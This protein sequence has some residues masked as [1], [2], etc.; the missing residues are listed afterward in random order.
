[1]SDE[2]SSYVPGPTALI[3]MELTFFCGVVVADGIGVKEGV[4]PVVGVAS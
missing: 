3:S 2:M 1:M 4:I